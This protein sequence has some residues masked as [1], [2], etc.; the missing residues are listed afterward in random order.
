MEE[1]FAFGVEEEDVDGAVAEA[2]LVDDAAALAADHFVA[3]VDDI[4]NILGFH[5]N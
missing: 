1:D 5:L 2:G 3:V 4:E